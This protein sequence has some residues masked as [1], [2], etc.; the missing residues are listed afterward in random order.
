MSN[1]SHFFAHYCITTK[2]ITVSTTKADCGR[3][4]RSTAPNTKFNISTLW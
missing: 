4:P 1:N 2:T 3:T